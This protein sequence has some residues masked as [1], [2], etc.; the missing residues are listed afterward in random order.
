MFKFLNN[1]IPKS[2]KPA[3]SDPNFIMPMLPGESL[4]IGYDAFTETEAFAPENVGRGY[5]QTNSTERYQPIRIPRGKID[6]SRLAH[7]I[8][9]FI[10]CTEGA[11]KMLPK[12]S[13]N[14]RNWLSRLPKKSLYH[15]FVR[16]SLFAGDT[17]IFTLQMEAFKYRDE[18]DEEYLE[19][20][21]VQNRGLGTVTRIFLKNL[22]EYLES[23]GAV[24]NEVEN[25]DS[26]SIKV[27]EED[28]LIS[29][30][31]GSAVTI[32]SKPRKD[33]SVIK[34]EN[35]FVLPPIPPP[36]PPKL[37]LV[38]PDPEPDPEDLLSKVS[39][40][41][42]TRSTNLLESF[43]MGARAYEEVD[44]MFRIDGVVDKSVNSIDPLKLFNG[45]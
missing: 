22:R 17:S 32:R 43:A 13:L 8:H 40:P 29:E 7:L 36:Q 2:T 42:L 3:E 21:V 19:I 24:F 31:Y 1:P 18:A 39:I 33:P 44:Y 28:D 27:W 9:K 37:S 38:M 41:V 6:S 14:R 10:S 15:A 34:P 16:Y 4:H 26:D 25:R 5:P 11:E 45:I 30:N 35:Q 12:F 20:G 23:D